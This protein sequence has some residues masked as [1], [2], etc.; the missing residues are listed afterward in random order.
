MDGFR[1]LLQLPDHIV[2]HTLIPIG[3]PAEQ[4]EKPDRFRAER[5]HRNGWS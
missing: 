3:Y 2:P 5:I 4:P 1:K